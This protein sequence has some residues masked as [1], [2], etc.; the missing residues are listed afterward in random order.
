MLG[1]AFAALGLAACTGE[2]EVVITNNCDHPVSVAA[3]SGSIGVDGEWFELQTGE[4]SDGIRVP[5][6][7]TLFLTVIRIDQPEVWDPIEVDQHN[8]DRTDGAANLVLGDAQ[9]CS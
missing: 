8:L 7:G 5:D 2:Q 9:L 6:S 3:R 1:V 4:G